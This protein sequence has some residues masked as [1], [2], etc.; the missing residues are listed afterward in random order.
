[1]GADHLLVAPRLNL[2]VSR[3]PTA[4]RHHHGHW[5]VFVCHGHLVNEAVAGLQA[6]SRKAEFAKPV[7]FETVHTRLV[8]DQIGSELPHDV[9]EGLGQQRQIRTV[10]STL[11]HFNVHVACFFGREVVG[12]AVHRQREHIALVLEQHGIAVALMHVQVH[13][14]DALNDVCIVSQRHVG[15]HRNVRKGAEALPTVTE[16]VMRA[17]CDVSGKQRSGWLL[18]LPLPPQRQ[19]DVACGGHRP[20]NGT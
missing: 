2:K 3:I 18:P 4:H 8:E 12:R 14:Q 15:G 16:G 9:G 19:T 20:S 5:C 10:T 7:G 6:S 11:R 17:T 1:M 13:D